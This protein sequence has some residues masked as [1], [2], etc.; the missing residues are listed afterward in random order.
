MG[1]LS[2]SHAAAVT[3]LLVAR[4][5]AGHVDSKGSSRVGSIKP[6]SQAAV[7]KNEAPVLLDFLAQRHS[8]AAE[9]LA[10]RLE[11]GIAEGLDAEGVDAAD[12]L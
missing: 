4:R 10:Q 2:Q 3:D 11:E 12:A 1:G 6:E 7:E 5:H 9:D 8:H